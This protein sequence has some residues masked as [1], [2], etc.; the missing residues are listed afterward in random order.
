[1]NNSLLPTIS[2]SSNKNI[3]DCI[4]NIRGRQVMLD[5]DIAAFF[6]VDTKRINEQMKRNK[7]RFPEDFC[8]QQILQ[9]LKL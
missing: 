8:F 6:A 5:S 3:E 7:A 9:N 4:Y 2:I 1:M